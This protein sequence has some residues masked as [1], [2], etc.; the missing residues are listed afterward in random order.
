MKKVELTT[1][2]L[3]EVW[4]D[5]FLTF[6]HGPGRECDNVDDILKGADK[7]AAGLLEGMV[8]VVKHLNGLAETHE[9]PDA[10]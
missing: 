10:K 6:V 9:K 8:Q 2:D 7:V 5:G 1:N 4:K 3:L